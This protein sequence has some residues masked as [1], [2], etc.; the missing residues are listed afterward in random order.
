MVILEVDVDTALKWATRCTEIIPKQGVSFVVLVSDLNSAQKLFSPAKHAP[1]SQPCLRSGSSNDDWIWYDELLWRKLKEA[2]GDTVRLAWDC[3]LLQDTNHHSWEVLTPGTCCCCV[4]RCP[5]LICSASCLPE[6]TCRQIHLTCCPL[7][8][9]VLAH[10]L[11]PMG[12][13]QF[14]D[15]F[16]QMEKNG[17]VWLLQQTT[18]SYPKMCNVSATKWCQFPP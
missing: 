3:Q 4:P 2:V 16:I 5:S 17:S 12:L 10:H 15:D 14:W 1:F 11:F 6:V 18:A 13:W 7:S 8:P 9:C